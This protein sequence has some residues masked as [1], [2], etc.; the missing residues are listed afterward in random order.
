MDNECIYKKSKYNC[1]N[2]CAL[3]NPQ[4]CQFCFS[5]SKCLFPRLKKVA[6]IDPKGPSEI[7]RRDDDDNSGDHGRSNGNARNGSNGF[8]STTQGKKSDSCKALG[9]AGDGNQDGIEGS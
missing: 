6:I 3:L 7:R 1:S 9:P 5:H 2:L 4:S 8:T